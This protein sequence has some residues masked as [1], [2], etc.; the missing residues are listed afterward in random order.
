[1][2]CKMPHISEP[3]LMLICWL[4]IWG[5]TRVESEGYVYMCVFMCL[6]ICTCVCL[7]I[8]VWVCVF[9]KRKR[10]SGVC[11]NPLNTT[12]NPKRID[13]SLGLFLVPLT[14]AKVILQKQGPFVKLINTHI[15]PRS[16]E[17]WKRIQGQESSCHPGCCF[18]PALLSASQEQHVPIIKPVASFFL[19]SPR[20]SCGPP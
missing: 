19:P 4:H 7:H 8:Y 9:I 5:S 16:Q 18:M 20:I 17:N 15:W 10:E 12:L 6:C 13:W 2:L 3:F 1:M 11:W 14:L